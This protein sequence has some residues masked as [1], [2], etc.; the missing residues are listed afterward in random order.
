MDRQ[1]GYEDR[2]TGECADSSVACTVAQCIGCYWKDEKPKVVKRRLI[3]GEFIEFP[4]AKQV[5]ILKLSDI[6]Q[7][8]ALVHARLRLLQHRP[9]VAQLVTSQAH[10]TPAQTVT[11]LVAA[12]MYDTAV[13]ICR[14][15]ALPMTSVFEGLASRCV[16]HTYFYS[17]LLLTSILLCFVKI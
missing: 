6:E 12:E 13:S 7:E 4:V 9:D 11:Q 5:E 3:A 2:R 8:Y 16:V 14:L 10:S 17:H 15:F 1:A